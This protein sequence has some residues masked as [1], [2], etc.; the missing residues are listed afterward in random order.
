METRP[1]TERPGYDPSVT[2]PPGEKASLVEDFIDVFYAPSSVFAR[3]RQSG[4]WMHLLIVAV[5]AGMFA[6]AN[7]GV[8]E[9]IF[10]AEFSRAAARMTQDPRM[11]Q[12]L[13][14]QQRRL[15]TGAM[16]LFQYVGT[17]LMIFTVAL[18]GWAVSR[19]M[20]IKLTYGQLAMIV[21]LSFIPRLLWYVL[22]TVQVL[23][24]DTTT[25][26][27]MFGLSVSPA[28]FMDPDSPNRMLMGL[29]SR[30]DVFVIWGTVL[31]GIGVATMGNV[32]RRKGLAV[33]G[34]VW[35]IAAVP[36]LFQR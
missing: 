1:D 26:T 3:R 21:T 14:D 5:I 10:E 11:T 9:Q 32:S 27:S 24:M 17:P 13:I 22:I 35:L 23:V 7:R 30:L 16:Q 12:D 15:S 34:V 31:I 36:M 20:S 2:S 8:F 28:R 25:T 19:M 4:F 33:A 29:A 6:F 18:V